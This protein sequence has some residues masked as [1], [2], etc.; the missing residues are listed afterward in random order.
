LLYLLVFTRDAGQRR[1]RMNT[2]MSGIENGM[3]VLDT[4]GEKIGRVT[5]VLAVRAVSQAASTSGTFGG[6]ST[7]S[8][9]FVDDTAA[10]YGTTGQGSIL[11]VQHGGLMGVGGTDLYIPVDDVTTVVPGDSVTIN[12]TKDT[13]ENLYS[14]KPAFLP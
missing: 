11:K 2:N 6:T 5:D 1:Q 13:C 4:M 10:G 14:Q 3:D 12:C 9:G 7:A 8:G